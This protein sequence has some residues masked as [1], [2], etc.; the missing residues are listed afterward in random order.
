M[1]ILDKLFIKKDNGEPSLKIIVPILIGINLL[2]RVYYFP[3][4]VPIAGDGIDYFMFAVSIAQNGEIPT[5]ILMT[6]DGW[7]I[8]LSGFFYLFGQN[9]MF[10]LM[11][12]QRYIS[13]MISVLT[14]VP[15]YLLCRKFLNVPLSLFGSSLFIFEP[16]VMQN[17]LIGITEPLF[18]F[19]VVYCI[20]LLYSNKSYLVYLS[21]VI[22]GLATIVRYEGVLLFIP[23]SIIFFLRHKTTRASLKNYLAS[24]GLFIMTIIPTSI[25]RIL[26]NDRDGIIS[27]VV[28]SVD[29]DMGAVMVLINSNQMGLNFFHGFF[30]FIKYLAWIAFPLFVILV[31]LG[32]F[33][34]LKIK[35]KKILEL[36]IFSIFLSVT[37][38]YAYIRDLQEIRYLFVLLPIFCIVSSYSFY[39]ID[40]KRQTKLLL[41]LIIIIVFSSFAYLE[42]GKTDY[43]IERETFDDAKFIIAH[44]QGM[45]YYD[46]GRYI[47]PASLAQSWP[48]LLELDE[49]KKTSSGI[50]KITLDD[51][52]SIHEALHAGKDLGLTHLIITDKNSSK[53]LANIF[54]NESQYPY[55][56]KIY[57]STL[58]GHKNPLKVFE[59]DYEKFEQLN[60]E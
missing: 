53:F 27:H 56:N 16:H 35:E 55:L 20:N 29:K 46:G 24:V 45:N 39:N 59:I 48:K 26:N 47:K 8:F 58:L 18:L 3:F 54:N 36:L 15:V 4:N 32:I 52:D 21:F 9:D 12:V 51:F 14:V 11:G 30:M 60:T 2:I 44:V 5:G 43:E 17:S 42:W 22:A 37:A 7:S 49:K 38:I 6:N 33:Q 23:L 19:L 34:I 25:L 13:I 41:S 57:D 1:N 28:G 31:P 40:R 50:K 10:F